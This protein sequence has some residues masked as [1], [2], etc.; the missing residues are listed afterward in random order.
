MNAI[1]QISKKLFIYRFSRMYERGADGN[2]KSVTKIMFFV[3]GGLLFAGSYISG[4]GSSS[5][6]WLVG[7]EIQLISMEL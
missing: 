5:Q 6:C 2:C 3:L 4:S 1:E 7:F